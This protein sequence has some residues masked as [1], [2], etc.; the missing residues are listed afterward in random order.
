MS[1]TLACEALKVVL[2]TR[3][4]NIF[5][6]IQFALLSTRKMFHADTGIVA[7]LKVYFH[8]AT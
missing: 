4:E 8:K 7:P 1:P 3:A 6:L 5:L 2:K